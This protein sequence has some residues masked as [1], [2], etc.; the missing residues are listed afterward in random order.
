[1]ATQ[2]NC[3]CYIKW[4]GVTWTH[5]KYAIFQTLKWTIRIFE[6]KQQYV[7]EVLDGQVGRS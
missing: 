1:M 7:R 4:E 6:E 3:N 5:T 2:Y